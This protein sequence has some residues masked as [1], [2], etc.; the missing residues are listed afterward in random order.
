MS[1]AKKPNTKMIKSTNQDG[2][3]SEKALEVQ[4]TD[5]HVENLAAVVQTP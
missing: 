3:F 5:V 1:Q 4:H 2:V